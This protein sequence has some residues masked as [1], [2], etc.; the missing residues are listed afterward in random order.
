MTRSQFF[1]NGSSLALHLLVGVWVVWLAAPVRRLGL[2][3]AGKTPDPTEVFVVPPAQPT[4]L[5]GLNPIDTSQDDSIIRREDLSSS[6]LSLPGFTFDFR[7]IATR[8]TLLFPFLT[9]GLSLERFVLTPRRA[10]VDSFLNPFASSPIAERRGARNKPPLVLGD[11]AM[12]SLIDQCWS[13][14]DRWGAFQR[15]VELAN[16]YDQDVGKLPAVFQTYLAQ[17]GLQPYVD[18]AIRD[19]RLWVELGLAADHV[20]FVGFVSRYASENP[21][22]KATTELLFLLDQL[23]Q[24]SLDA[25]VT[26]VNISPNEDL[27]WTRKVNG[28]AFNLIGDL[29]R[30]YKEQLER[31]GLASAGALRAYYDHVRLTILTSILRTTPHGYR[32]NDARFLI[33]TIYWAQGQAADALRSWRDIRIDP[34]DRYA[35]AYSDILRALDAPPDRTGQTVN[36]TQVDHA[37]R[38]EHG[39]WIS[40]SIDRLHRFGYHFDTF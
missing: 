21:S 28:G 1:A 32:A 7:K 27:T 6:A 3:P 2:V 25:L 34:K 12:Q 30:Y 14:R 36:A 10:I 24:A 23:A 17:D 40:T 35:T 4:T 31:K 13:R 5:P 19:P 33:G 15:L 16:T 18:T 38:A 37:L 29:Q 26:L 39:R 22:S 20:N 9:P 8:A 11:T